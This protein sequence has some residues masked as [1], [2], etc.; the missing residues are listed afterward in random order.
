MGSFAKRPLPFFWSRIHQLE[1]GIGLYQGTRTKHIVWVLFIA[2]WEFS[3]LWFLE[4]L[5]LAIFQPAGG[6]VEMKIYP[7]YRR[8]AL[9]VQ[10]EITWHTWDFTEIISLTKPMC[11]YEN[12]FSKAA[13]C[14][15]Q[16][17]NI[18][19]LLWLN[20]ALLFRSAFE[21]IS[22]SYLL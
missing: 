4:S 2:D 13:T 22:P 15:A 21:C 7:W 11:N 18:Y 14:A 8:Q 3:P 1:F 6:K 16:K 20:T 17:K 5:H 9:Q 19:L 12:F 10:W